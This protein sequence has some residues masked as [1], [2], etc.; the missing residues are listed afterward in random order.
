[1]LISHSYFKLSLLTLAIFQTQSS[2]ADSTEKL[3][4][5]VIQASSSPDQASSEKTKAPISFKN[6]TVQRNL[7]FPSKKHHKPLML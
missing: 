6:R 5:E 1:M 4:T 3:P 7:I 2:F